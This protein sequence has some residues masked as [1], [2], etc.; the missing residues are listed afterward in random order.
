[1]PPRFTYWTIIVGQQAT[2]FRSQTRE[3]LL[4]TLK[5]IQRRHPD[6]V[7]MWFARGRLWHSPQEARDAQQRRRDTP[8]ARST[9]RR[10]QGWR[11]GGEHRDP[12]DRFKVPRAVR[13]KRFAE[14]QRRDRVSPLPPRPRGRLPRK[15]K[16]EE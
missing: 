14:R 10:G 9:E 7:M 11:P 3:E 4:P 16:D 5:Q 1:M 6:A 12:R 8:R 2:A 15:K 13:R